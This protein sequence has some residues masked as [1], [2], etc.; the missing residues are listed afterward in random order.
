MKPQP[1]IQ[2]LGT[3][4]L[5]G[6]SLEMS[7]VENRTRELWQRFMPD[8]RK[9]D[10]RI[11]EDLYSIQIF[12]PTYFQSFDP[13]KTFIKWAAVEVSEVNGKPREMDQVDLAGGQYAVF[14]YKGMPGDPKIFQYIYTEWL[15]ASRY[16]LDNRPHFEI[17]G[18]KYK[19]NSQDSEEEIWIPVVEK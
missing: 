5:V 9:V 18:S 15:P 6:I 13:H 10:N 3:K 7:L 14:N 11:N 1:K 17:L 8:R 19:H 12:D 2:N 16:R 4:I